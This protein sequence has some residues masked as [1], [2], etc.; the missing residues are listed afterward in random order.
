LVGS[1]SCL[2]V[3]ASVDS[4]IGILFVVSEVGTLVGP[5]VTELV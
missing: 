2:L 4:S 5:F 1:I 3:L